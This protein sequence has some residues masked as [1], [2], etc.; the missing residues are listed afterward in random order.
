MSSRAVT[1][2]QVRNE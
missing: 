2:Q 1:Q